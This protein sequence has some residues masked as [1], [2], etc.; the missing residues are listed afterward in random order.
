MTAEL[1]EST[2]KER[3]LTRKSTVD[4]GRR[5]L[6]VDNSDD[7]EDEEEVEDDDD[8]DIPIAQDPVKTAFDEILQI[9]KSGKLKLGKREERK[10][11]FD[12]Y[13]RYIEKLVD[14]NK[15]L[16]HVLAYWDGATNSST[17]SLISKLTAKYPE[18]YSRL[19]VSRDYTGSE[20]NPLYAAISRKD[21]KL[22]AYMCENKDKSPTVQD[23]LVDALGMQCSERSENCLTAAIRHKLPVDIILNLIEKTTEDALKAQDSK[24]F[25][26]L[27]YAVE[28]ERCTHSQFE[29][30]RRLIECGDSA[31]DKLGNKPDYFS[32]YG[33]HEST[34]EKYISSKKSGKITGERLAEWTPPTKETVLSQPKISKEYDG[35][36]QMAPLPNERRTREDL[37]FK[38]RGTNLTTEPNGKPFQMQNSLLQTNQ[39]PNVTVSADLKV[40]STLPAHISNTEVSRESSKMRSGKLEEQAVTEESAEKIREMLHLHY[41]RTRSPETAA[42]RLYGKSTKARHICFDYLGAPLKIDPEEFIESFEHVK[43]D[44]VLQYVAFPNVRVHPAPDYPYALDKSTGDG[45]GRCDMMFFFQWLKDKGVKRI[46]KVIVDDSNTPAHSDEAIE[47]ALQGFDV[48]ILDWRKVDLCPETIWTASRKLREVHLQWSGNN[49]VL[50]GW[51]ESE[52]LRRLEDLTKVHLHVKQDLESHSRMQKKIGSF[53]D[54]LNSSTSSAEQQRTFSL[55]VEQPV[56]HSIQPRIIQ[57]KRSDEDGQNRRLLTMSFAAS[58]MKQEHVLQPHRWLNCMDEFKDVFQNVWSWTMKQKLQQQEALKQPVEIALIDD[59]VDVL[60]SRLRGK[61]SDGKSFDYGDK[62]ANRIRSHWISERGHGTVMAKNI[63]RICPMAK[64]YVIKLET[65][66]D[67][68]EQKARIGARS[69]AEAIDAAVDRKVQIISMSWTIKQPDSNSEEKEKFDSAVHRAVKAGILLFCSAADKGLHQDNDYP[70][71]SNPTKMFKIGAAKPNGNV[72]DWVPNIRHLDFIIPG[73][74]VAENASLDD[75]SSQNFQPQTGS[76]VATALG[77]GLAA[78]VICCVQLASIHTQMSRQ[79]GHP[80]APS[81][82][83]LDDLRHVKNHENMKAALRTIGTSPDSDNKFIEVWR[84]FDKAAKDMAGKDKEQQL[85]VIVTLAYKFRAY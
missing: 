48:E 38:W 4:N 3:P 73:Y 55:P 1:S 17:K 14:E 60:Q 27:H 16:L 26:P 74:E 68:K 13:S 9:I 44:T 67:H 7:S 51:S 35:P 20:S 57:V 12:K 75:D 69:A 71:A 18:E 24:G 50:R 10:K 62:G 30:I 85:E 6:N 22:V 43:L 58:E 53:C 59:G 80:D 56:P 79:K 63:V 39:I 81:S 78:L 49:A 36:K 21:A 70:A 41:L 46:L 15:N 11:F 28:Y 42:S 34:R 47:K 29:I 83:T 19:L 25:T 82:L 66:F 65:H 32:V 2:E 84:L 23:A 76:S 77:A 45:N 5:I 72:W 31:L 52:G 8:D 37:A 40:S 64:I 61:I 33:Y 54:R